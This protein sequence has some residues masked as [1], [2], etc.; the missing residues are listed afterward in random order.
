MKTV[1]AVKQDKAQK[2]VKNEAGKSVRFPSHQKDV[3]PIMDDET[4]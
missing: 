2:G 1:D 4:S 3:N